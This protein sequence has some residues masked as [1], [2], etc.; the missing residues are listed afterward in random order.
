MA[1]LDVPGAML[2]VTRHAREQAEENFRWRNLQSSDLWRLKG[3]FQRQLKGSR[4][5]HPPAAG[6]HCSGL[7]YAQ[8]LPG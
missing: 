3:R 4:E 7:L 5:V 8:A 1:P 2:I 6:Q